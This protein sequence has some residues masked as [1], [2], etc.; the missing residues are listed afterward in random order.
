M[1]IPHAEIAGERAELSCPATEQGAYRAIE[2]AG[3]GGDPCR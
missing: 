3:N 1:W 2:A